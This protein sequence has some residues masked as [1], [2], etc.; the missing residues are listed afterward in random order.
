MDPLAGIADFVRSRDAIVHHDRSSSRS[1]S[2]GVRRSNLDRAAD[3]LS[4]DSA[5]E[6]LGVP[7]SS[8][9]TSLNPSLAHLT[10]ARARATRPS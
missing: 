9:S 8:S 2:A 6:A 3:P 7:A 10:S 1:G 4:Q 5:A